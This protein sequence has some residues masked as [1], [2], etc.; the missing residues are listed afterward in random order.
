MTA[1]RITVLKDNNK[2]EYLIVKSSNVVECDKF[3]NGFLVNLQSSTDKEQ[4][5]IIISSIFIKFTRLSEAYRYINSHLVS[6]H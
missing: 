5:Q 4:N 3:D 2:N 6:R 1:G